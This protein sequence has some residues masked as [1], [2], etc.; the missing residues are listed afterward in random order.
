M[1]RYSSSNSKSFIMENAITPSDPQCLIIVDDIEG[2]LVSEWYFFFFLF[3]PVIEFT[4][5]D[6]SPVVN[7]LRSDI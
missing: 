5:E 4:P 7:I 6:N 3:L 1:W 2:L